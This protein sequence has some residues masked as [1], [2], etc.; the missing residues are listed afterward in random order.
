MV[1]S[2]SSSFGTSSRSGDENS[3]TRMTGMRA[4]VC[5]LQSSLHQHLKMYDLLLT[6]KH[7]VFFTVIL[8]LRTCSRL[9]KFY[10]KLRAGCCSYLHRYCTYFKLRAGA[11]AGEEQ[12][13]KPQALQALCHDALG[14]YEG[15]GAAP[16]HLPT[17]FSPSPERLLL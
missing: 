14:C 2:Y 10:F 5:N 4:A 1:A 6:I 16:S 8:L 17:A 12:H 11:L 7:G 15:T 9:C 13:H 3:R